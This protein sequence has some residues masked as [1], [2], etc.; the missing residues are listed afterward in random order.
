MKLN[1]DS[2]I[3]K[4][5]KGAN[6]MSSKPIFKANTKIAI[7]RLSQQITLDSINDEDQT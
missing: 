4:Q 1:D 5:R 3:F 6:S 2:P 7:K